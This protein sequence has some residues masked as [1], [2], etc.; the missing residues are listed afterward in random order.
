[1]GE[2]IKNTD[3]EAK[4][5]SVS[6]ST[7]STQVA[8]SQETDLIML[9]VTMLC[10][11]S[12][13]HH[14]W[15]RPSLHSNQETKCR[16]APQSPAGESLANHLPGTRENSRREN[17]P[18]HTVQRHQAGRAHFPP[19]RLRSTKGGEER[20]WPTDRQ[21]DRTTAGLPCRA[22]PP[23]PSITRGLTGCSWVLP[24]EG[25]DISEALRLSH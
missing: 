23:G 25:G 5:L 19:W 21:T 7:W 22:V 12:G 14:C 15:Q 20:S 17:S 3:W 16:G 18:W 2:Q 8:D 10:P 9:L 13:W 1:M 4:Q 11:Y 6:L 24:N